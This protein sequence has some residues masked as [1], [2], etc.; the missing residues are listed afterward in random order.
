M[1]SFEGWKGLSF[2]LAARLGTEERAAIAWAAL[3]MLPADR[4]E[5]VVSAA[6]GGAG[7]PLPALQAPMDEARWWAEWASRP[8]LKAWCLASFEALP[9]A[10]QLAFLAYVQRREA[11]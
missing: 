4:V 7:M 6:L 8:E 5:S 10:D 9:A 11:A 2:I 1:S 3:G